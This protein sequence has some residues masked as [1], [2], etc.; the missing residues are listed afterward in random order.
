MHRSSESSQRPRPQALIA[1]NSHLPGRALVAAAIA[2]SLTG[3]ATTTSFARA[4][5]Q[6]VNQQLPSVVLPSGLPSF[7]DVVER[8]T[9]AVVNVTVAQEIPERV[10]G[11]HG[12]LPSLPEGT[13]LREF[14]EQF[15]QQFGAAPEQTTPGFSIPREGEGS[16]FIVDPSGYIVTNNHVID[17][18][19]RIEVTL[20]DGT[21][22]DAQIVGRDAKTDL[23]L[24][25][26]DA[27]QPL[28]HV[29]LGSAEH[30]RVGDWVLAVGNPF[31]LGGTVN[32][33]IISARGRDIQSGPYDD[34]LQIDA[35]IN[36]G[37]S[38]GPLFDVNGNVIGVNTAIYSPTGG[39]I[40]I[41]FAIP[42]ETV[43]GVV[44][45]LRTKGRVDRGWLG[46]QIQPVTEEVAAS[47]G[48]A[49][50]R[51]VLV[52]DVLPGTPAEAAGVR[53]GDVILAVD[54]EQMDDYRE[55]TRLIASIDAG[56]KVDLTVMRGGKTR[57]IGVTIGSMPQ[58]D[59]AAA[60]AAPTTGPR[61]EPR[62]GL[63]L[64][65]LTPELR[66]ERGLPSDAS[67]VVVS[68]VQPGSPAARSG[69]EA[70]S[71]ISMVGQQNVDSPDQVSELVREAIEQK[72][73]AVLL[74]VEQDGEQRFVA[75]PLS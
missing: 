51:G 74:R 23:A 55:L 67:G 34:Y 3:L 65:P 35:P 61:D 71:L 60:G 73:P 49:D 7:A 40:G 50:T 57:R 64:M 68:R 70:G 38:G 39:N 54:D 52:A 18:A 43:A 26:I 8:V 22:F 20:N 48:L 25:K 21:E 56:S 27:D 4:E 37:N 62:I 29:D 2:L 28:P 47:L 14:F 9:P 17:K 31:G 6:A 12:Q 13:P 44:D 59:V 46:V 1:T 24:I 75:V 15:A 41:G 58:Q 11:F 16:G 72:R 32:A 69:I 30:A 42:A 45:D 53:S 5:P 33:G 19:D 36:R 66:S 10:G 63:Y